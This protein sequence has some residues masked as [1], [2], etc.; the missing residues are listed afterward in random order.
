M[1]MWIIPFWHQYREGLKK[2][3]P[4]PF[5]TENAG[6][7]KITV[8]GIP[9]NNVRLFVA[10]LSAWIGCENKQSVLYFEFDLSQHFSFKNIDTDNDWNK[11]EIDAYE[12]YKTVQ[13]EAYA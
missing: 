7:N 11:D 8:A 12:L 10:M 2:N 4:Q 3:L 9:F 13:I 1:Y 5:V 6:Y